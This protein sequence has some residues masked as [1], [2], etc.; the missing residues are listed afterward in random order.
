M[1]GPQA[2]LL[3]Q[4]APLFAGTAWSHMA[5]QFLPAA[6]QSYEICMDAQRWWKE[7]ELLDT[8]RGQDN[9]VNAPTCCTLASCCFTADWQKP[10][11]GQVS[12]MLRSGLQCRDL[13]PWS[14]NSTLT[15]SSDGPSAPSS[16][17]DSFLPSFSLQ[18]KMK[19]ADALGGMLDSLLNFVLQF[20]CDQEAYL[21]F[22][23][24]ARIYSYQQASWM[25]PHRFRRFEK[26][27]RLW[28][29]SKL[30]S[31]KLIFW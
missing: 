31:L 22:N 16:V 29:P 11:S 17:L 14:Q 20:F 6:T 5:H 30:A 28:C 25:L 3:V 12:Q 13:Q 19:R 15:C 4:A 23:W 21:R 2:A 27:L 10:I 9:A 7:E 1:G 18:T 26:D 24:I 8:K